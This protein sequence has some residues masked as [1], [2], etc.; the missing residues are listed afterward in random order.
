MHHFWL[1]TVQENVSLRDAIAVAQQQLYEA[2]AAAASQVLAEK[3]LEGEQQARHALEQ[4]HLLVR[5]SPHFLCLSMRLLKLG[6]CC[7]FSKTTLWLSVQALS[8]AVE[9][10]VSASPWATASKLCQLHNMG[11]VA[12]DAC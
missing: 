6:S 3:A 5:P 1:E 4:T 2:A 8:F 9:S 11:H 10:T 12:I 7:V